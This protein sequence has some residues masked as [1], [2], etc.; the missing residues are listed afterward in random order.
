MS[1]FSQLLDWIEARIDRPAD[2]SVLRDPDRTGS[3]R[4]LDTD[5]PDQARAAAA[6]VRRTRSSTRRRWLGR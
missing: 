5:D 1:R 6:T 2:Q 4:M 3:E